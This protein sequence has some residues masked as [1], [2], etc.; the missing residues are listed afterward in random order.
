M[1]GDAAIKTTHIGQNIVQIALVMLV[2]RTLPGVINLH[3]CSIPPVPGF[4]VVG[5]IQSTETLIFGGEPGI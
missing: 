4:H 1:R 3:R 5:Y 2:K